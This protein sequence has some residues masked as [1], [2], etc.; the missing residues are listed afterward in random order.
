MLAIQAGND[1]A[2]SCLFFAGAFG[3]LILLVVMFVRLVDSS[4]RIAA[5]MEKLTEQ[6]DEMIRGRSAE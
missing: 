4:R 1:A 6:M 2:F 5:A 3:I